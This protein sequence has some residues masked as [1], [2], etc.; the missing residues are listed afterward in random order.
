M[1]TMTSRPS[2]MHGL[3]IVG[4][5]FVVIVV[6]IFGSVGTKTVPAYLDFNTVKTA[7]NNTLD[8]PKIGLLSEVEIQNGVD[9]RL[10]INNVSVVRGADLEVE[11]AGGRVKVVV[12]YEVRNN[13]FGNLDVVMVFNREFERSFR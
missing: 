2:R 7:I 12:D 3:T 1:K 4:W 13:L 9:R 8:D 5:M 6:V 10:A 11:K